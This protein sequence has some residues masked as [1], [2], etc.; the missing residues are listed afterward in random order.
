MKKNEEQIISNNPF[1]FI[2][3]IHYLPPV[4]FVYFL[5]KNST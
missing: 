3:I 5:K 2:N 4:F 1:E